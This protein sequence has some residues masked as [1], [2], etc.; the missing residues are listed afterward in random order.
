MGSGGLS[1]RSGRTRTL[2]ERCGQ[3][4]VLVYYGMQ[5]LQAGTRELMA[6]HFEPIE[7]P[8][9]DQAE[10]SVLA[11]AEA[12]FA[13]MGFRFDK[14]RFDSHPNLKTIGTPTTG[15]PHIDEKEAEARG[16]RIR[17]LREHKDL[18]ATI[19]STAELGWGML[20][21]LTRR[22]PQAFES[23][24]ARK[25][26]GKRFGAKTPRM[27]S[28]MELGVVGL[29]RLGGF[30]AGYGRAFCRAVRYFDPHVR[31]DE[32][33][34]CADPLELVRKSDIVSIHV[35]SAPDTIGMVNREFLL[36]MGQGSFLINTARGDLVDEAA[37][38]EALSS[39]QIGG[40]ALDTLDGEHLPGFKENLFSHP[41]VKYARENDN[42]LLTPHYGGCT[43]DAWAETEIRIV[44]A[45]AHD[46][47]M[48]DKARGTE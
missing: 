12:A 32:Y 22:I 28:S 33:E 1:A 21:C 4:P 16:I 30:M 43:M 42:L 14:A 36:A 39:G 45:M 31:S 6:Q 26:E 24:L 34:S 18:L 17:S 40:A 37:L 2:A 3:K 7:F 20:I 19:S 9:P 13:P 48:L 11:R 15:I 35:H 10:P 29:G 47:G 38:L 46:C 5:D 27:L 23:V 25:W 8:D 44:R 41:L